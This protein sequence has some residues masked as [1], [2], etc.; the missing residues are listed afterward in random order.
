MPLL[1]LLRLFLPL[2]LITFSGCA[3]LTALTTRITRTPELAYVPVEEEGFDSVRHRLDVFAPRQKGK[4]AP[5]L[6]FIHGGKWNTGDKRLYRFLGSRL[7]RKGVVAVNINYRLSPQVAYEGMALDAARAVA[8]VQHHIRQ[9]GGDPDRIF[10]AGHS[11]GGHLAALLTV[12]DRFFDSLGLRNP[13]KGAV[14]IDAAGL[15]MYNYLLEEQKPPGHTYLRTFSENPDIWKEASPRY[16][17]QPGQP[18]LLIYR[19]GRTYPSIVK[20]TEAFV[21]DLRPLVPQLQYRVQRRLG[22]IPMIVQFVYAW[23]P[24]YREI[25]R[26]MEAPD[27]E[28]L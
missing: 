10:V 3:A 24:R 12:Q 14:L 2:L 19:G 16:H 28:V 22:H 18:P 13:V 20:S 9:Y 17:L 8:W 23:N 15:D 1:P 21:G 11:A 25:L 27:R 26:F 6:V 4:G 5:V 7:A